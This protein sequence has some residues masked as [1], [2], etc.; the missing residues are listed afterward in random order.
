MNAD[1]G[2]PAA[3]SQAGIMS[4]PNQAAAGK[5]QGGGV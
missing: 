1:G 4:L 2:D 3:F 5:P